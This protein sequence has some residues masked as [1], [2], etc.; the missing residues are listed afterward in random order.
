MRLRQAVGA[1]AEAV[2]DARGRGAI[3]FAFLQRTREI[4][5][6][7]DRLVL[8]R[9]RFEER[10]KESTQCRLDR[11]EFQWKAQL[12]GREPIAAI[13]LH[14]R[15]ADFFQAVVQFFEVLVEK[16]HHVALLVRFVG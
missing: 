2:G 16:P 5:A 7:E 6:A 15:D 10:G 3:G 1:Q 12:T 14:L 11:R 13:D 4:K 9:V 8:E